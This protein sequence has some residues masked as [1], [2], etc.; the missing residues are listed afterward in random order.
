MYQLAQL[1]LLHLMQLKIHDRTVGL[2]KGRKPDGTLDGVSEREL[3]Q[4]SDEQAKLAE[5]VD[6]MVQ[7]DNA[8]N[9]ES[10]RPQAVEDDLDRTLQEAGAPGF[11]DN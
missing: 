6:Q 8:D 10:R 4:L 7:Q 5:L 9:R 3:Q 2:E 1:R 11:G